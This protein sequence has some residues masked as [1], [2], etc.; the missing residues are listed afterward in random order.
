MIIS[1]DGGNWGQATLRAWDVMGTA[2][3]S[4]GDFRSARHHREDSERGKCVFP[5]STLVRGEGSFFCAREMNELRRMPG[6]VVPANWT[7]ETCT[8]F[9]PAGGAEGGEACRPGDV[10]TQ[11]CWGSIAMP[12]M[13]HVQWEAHT[14]LQLMTI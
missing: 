2:K 13:R 12:S 11:E 4:L 9:R 7:Q 8:S 5:G 3:Q 6:E 10:S 14:R 1:H